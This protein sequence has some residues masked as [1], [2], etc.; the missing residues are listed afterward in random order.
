MLISFF[1]L[2]QT[3]MAYPVGKSSRFKEKTEKKLFHKHN[4]INYDNILAKWLVNMIL[5]F[6][7]TDFWVIFLLILRVFYVYFW[8]TSF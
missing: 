7:E 4:K 2:K 5:S 6:Y 1:E 3:W 8:M